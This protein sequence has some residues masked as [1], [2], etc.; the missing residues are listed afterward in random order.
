MGWSFIG[1]LCMIPFGYALAHGA[2]IFILMPLIFWVVSAIGVHFLSWQWKF[3]KIAGKVIFWVIL[4]IILWIAYYFFI[5]PRLNLIRI[6]GHYEKITAQSVTVE[7]II[8]SWG[9]IGARIQANFTMD[10]HGKKESW[11]ESGQIPLLEFSSGWCLDSWYNGYKPKIEKNTSWYTLS[12]ETTPIRVT[13]KDGEYC[14]RTDIK[15]ERKCEAMANTWYFHFPYI[16]WACFRWTECFTSYTIP[17]TEFSLK[18][19]PK[20]IEKISECVNES[21]KEPFE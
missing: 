20:T 2:E 21:G 4:L 6:K 19:D 10:P 11:F 14:V 16:E 9:V 13:Q 8:W 15:S 7:N 17:W 5:S 3:L 18:V 1:F 12:V